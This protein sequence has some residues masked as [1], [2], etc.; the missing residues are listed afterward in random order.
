MGVVSFLSIILD[1]FR[2]RRYCR[3]GV[4]HTSER[5]GEPN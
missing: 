4:A 3:I 5:P 1:C 2:P